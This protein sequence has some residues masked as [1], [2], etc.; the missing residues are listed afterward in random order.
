MNSGGRCA[1]RACGGDDARNRRSLLHLW[2]QPNT[3]ETPIGIVAQRI[4]T[5]L[6]PQQV[7]GE[8]ELVPGIAPFGKPIYQFP[9][10]TA[11]LRGLR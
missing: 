7:L 1:P 8:V 11:P 9:L 2:F 5:G 10:T 6:V 4:F 3:R